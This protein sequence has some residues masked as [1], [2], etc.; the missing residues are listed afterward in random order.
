HLPALTALPQ[1]TVTRRLALLEHSHEGAGPT[2][3][4]LG[5]ITWDDASG[6]G[7]AHPLMWSDEVAVSPA[8]GATEVW[9]IFNLTPDAHPVH[10]HEVVF[11]VLNRQAID[12]EEDTVALEEESDPQ[13]PEPWERGRKDTVIAL[14]GQVTRIRARF[15]TAGQYVW[16]CH[17]LEHEDNEMMLPFRIGPVQPGQPE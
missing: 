14:P 13:P 11:E 1:H 2:A 8:V 7:H 5:A 12:V 10:V 4:L 15:A 9:E 3:A 16:H 17:I 6:T